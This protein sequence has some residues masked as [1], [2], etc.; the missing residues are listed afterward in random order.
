M[1]MSAQTPEGKLLAR[2][3]EILSDPVHPVLVAA[4]GVLKGGEVVF[5]NTVGKKRLDGAAADADTK[6]RIASISKLITAIGVWQLIER[7]AI[8]PETDVSRYLG[9]ILRNPAYPDTP[10]TVRMLLSHTSSI[11]EGGGKPG[12]YN[13]PYG[14]PVSEFFTEGKPYYNPNCWAPAG[15]APGVFFAYCNMNYC[16]L[17]TIIEN[18]S[19]ERFDRYMTDHVFAPMGL[20][21]GFN[22]AV[23]SHE[24][25]AQVGT[26]Y[27]K[28]NAAGEE[29]GVNGVWTAQQDDFTAGYPNQNYS[30]YVIGTN[31]SLFGPMGSLRISMNELCKIMQM[32]C[33]HPEAGNRGTDVHSRL[34]L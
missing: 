2:M 20:S 19:G 17:G 32:F 34:D 18:V 3:N 8:D 11:R 23:M 31:G 22:V 28:L 9:F 15:E 4:V 24:A 30:D 6:F 13:I 7:G 12:T 33:T 21:C 26:L 16:L 29:D 27:R 1:T 10:I 25:Q 14:H 5:S